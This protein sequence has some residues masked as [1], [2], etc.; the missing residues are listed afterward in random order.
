MNPLRMSL[1]VG[2]LTIIAIPLVIMV[3]EMEALVPLLVGALTIIVI[4][5]IVLAVESA[6]KLGSG[7]AAQ[8][9]ASGFVK[10]VLLLV[11]VLGGL[12]FYNGDRKEREASKPANQTAPQPIQTSSTDSKAS[13]NPSSGDRITPQDAD[14]TKY[15]LAAEQ[16]VR[17]LAIRTG[18]TQEEIRSQTWLMAKTLRV[19]KG[20]NQ[21]K[22]SLLEAMLDIYPQATMAM[23]YNDCLVLYGTQRYGGESHIDAVLN[24]KAVLRGLGA[25]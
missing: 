10:G 23:T 7:R 8:E 15:G 11:V 19:K 25:R 4:P 22:E 20:I 18:E 5:L 12:H 3:D 13:E 2:T 14:D 17:S 24:A 16:N 1:L 6:W 21:S 9:I